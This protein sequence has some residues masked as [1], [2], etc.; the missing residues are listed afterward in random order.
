MKKKE[1]IV[2]RK[3]IVE[4]ALQNLISHPTE[5][6][7]DYLVYRDNK[8][9]ALIDNIGASRHPEYKFE[10]YKARRNNKEDI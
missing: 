8:L 5:S 4:E 2:H 6:N 7:R 9:K 10:A 3:Y 1:L